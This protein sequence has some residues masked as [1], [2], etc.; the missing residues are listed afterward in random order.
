MCFS[1]KISDSGSSS[2]TTLSVSKG[3]YDEG[4]CWHPEFDVVWGEPVGPAKRTGPH[5]WTRNYT[6]CNVAVDVSKAEQGSVDLLA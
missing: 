5:S 2:G 3:W 1:P 4:F 6:R